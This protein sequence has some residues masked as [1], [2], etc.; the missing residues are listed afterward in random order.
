VTQRPVIV[1]F[2]NDLRL[3][4]NRALLAATATGAPLLPV[5]VLDDAAASAWVPGGASRWWLDKS[6]AA[7]ATDIAAGGGKLV[8]R[9]GDAVAALSAL[10]GEIGAAAVYCT[11][12][13]EP[14]ASRQE[15]SVKARLEADG[16]ALKRYGGAL[17]REPEELRTKGGDPFKVYSPMW[18][19]LI[20]LG[21]P[22][23][24]QPAPQRIAFLAKAPKSERL[25]DWKLHPK[26]PDW[27]RGLGERWRPGEAGARQ[28][29]DRFLAEA[30][31]GYR[32]DRNR[33]DIEGTS[34]LSPH[35]HFGEISPAVC[36]HRARAV[37]AAQSAAE[38]GLETFLKELVWRE[39]SYHL[40]VHWP[41][42]PEAPF[43]AE[44]ARFPW[45][46]D[47]AALTAWQRGR[48]G[49]PIVDAG[50]RELWTTG[51]M[52]NRVRM[53]VASFLVKDLMIPWQRGEAWFWDTLVDSDLASNA[54]S[55]Q[56]VAGS[57]ADA[58]PYF[59]IFNPVTQ[60]QKFDPDGDYVRRWVPEL[61]R[62]PS[63]LIH[64]PWT[65]P[66]LV[67]AAA[68]VELGRDY[69]LP[70]VEHGAARARALAAFAALKADATV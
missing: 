45:V 32:E 34:R 41:D 15:S 57:G 39:F 36:W 61:S 43:R 54:A 6:L 51:W 22:R 35:L 13:Y 33:P 66:A 23:T 12:A 16:I 27:S 59:R 56:W 19:A 25:A 49:Y 47:N 48:T 40:L 63:E 1:W 37:A 3:E 26:K 70:I 9:R 44:F 31:A 60:G 5:F 38:A 28:R 65:A 17:L 7:L 30:L 50:M 8:L 18:R 62:L 64:E 2:R 58:A 52:H 29:L 4:D 46:E 10:A 14:W 11:R 53:I 42:L 68:G 20:A 55:W 67:L 24:P 69:P 21:E